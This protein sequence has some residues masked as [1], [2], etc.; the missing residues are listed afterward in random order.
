MEVHAHSHTPRKKWTHYFW[1]FLMLFLAVFAGFLAEN[2]REHYVEQHRAKAYAQS[3]FRDL[4]N[5]TAEL[6]IAAWYENKTIAMIDS[7]VDFISSRNTLQKNGQLYYY[8]RLAGWSYNVDWSKATLT[9]LINSGNLRYFTNTQLVTQISSYNTLAKIITNTDESIDARRTRAAA[10]KDRILIAKYQQALS[11][12]SMDDL[13][14]GRKNVFVDSMRNTDVPVQSNVSDLINAFT[15]AIL[16]TKNLRQY[17]Q[18]KSYP[19]AIKEA[20]EIME[21]LKKE[22]HLK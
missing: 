21:L 13:Y 1:E 3:L 5:D 20:T 7:L 15:N 12:I 14:Y 17:Q 19:Q 4:Q 18:I 11:S 22:Y 8:M 10:Y 6:R 2:K 16:D 9:Q